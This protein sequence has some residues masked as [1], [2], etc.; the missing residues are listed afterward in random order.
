LYLY[1]ITTV[2]ASIGFIY[3]HV[4]SFL[5]KDKNYPLRS[6]A[7]VYLK[8][9]NYYLKIIIFIYIAEKSQKKV[10]NYPFS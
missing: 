8:E 10:K 7:L 9:N 4:H 5:V 1:F 2:I 6:I 3:F